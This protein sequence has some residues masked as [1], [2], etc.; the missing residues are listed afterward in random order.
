MVEM[1]IHQTKIIVNIRYYLE[2]R[3][4]RHKIG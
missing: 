3:F 4:I 1:I 2:S